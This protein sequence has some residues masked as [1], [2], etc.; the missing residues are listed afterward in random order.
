MR[1]FRT[2]FGPALRAVTPQLPLRAAA[3][4]AAAARTLGFCSFILSL[5]PLGSWHA[6]LA[7][8]DPGLS[9]ASSSGLRGEFFQFTNAIVIMP[10][11]NGRVPDFAA[12][13]SGVSFPNTSAAF[14]TTDGF[15][16]TNSQGQPFVTT[17]AAR[18]TGSITLSAAG[19]Y[20]FDVS[21][22]DGALLKLNGQPVL[23][24]N[25]LTGCSQTST[26][27]S[28]PAGTFPIELDYFQNFGASCLDFR[29]S[30][31]GAVTFSPAAVSSPIEA[32]IAAGFDLK[33]FAENIG[34][35][36]AI[37]FLSGGTFGEGLLVGDTASS[38]GFGA[39]LKF[40]R[41]G[42]ATVVS[43]TIAS[44]QGFA[45][46]PGISFGGALFVVDD[47]IP[48]NSFPAPGNRDAGSDHLKRI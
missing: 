22:D 39:V 37:S 12:V 43:G 8:A 18:F 47:Y 29:V 25:Y 15:A 34:F 40:D 13:F 31:P 10:N 27:L 7:A 14:Q 23:D 42:S 17:F 45:L 11:V 46:S 4:M 38:G 16:P 36:T 20:E 33:V 9:L 35:P 5:W 30:G 41:A 26:K 32:T 21:S 2:L 6:A 24:R 44:P 19:D 28:L 1:L 48:G 3:R